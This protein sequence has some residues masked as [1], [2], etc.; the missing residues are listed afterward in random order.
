MQRVL[1]PA[2]SFPVQ[3]EPRRSAPSFA[4]SRPL[5]EFGADLVIQHRVCHAGAVSRS[6]ITSEMAGKT[7]AVL[8]VGIDEVASFRALSTGLHDRLDPRARARAAWGGLQDSAPRSALLALHARVHSITPRAWEDPSFV[9]LWLRKAAYLVP[10]ADRAVFTL[11]ALPRDPD[12][13]AALQHLADQVV[14]A[15]G[16]NAMSYRELAA[17]APELSGRLDVRLTSATGK[18][19]L[20]W[21]AS[22]IRV[23]PTSPPE[24]DEEE[25]RREL[26]RRFLSWLGPSSVR[27]FSRWSGISQADAA[28]T[29]RALEPE[30]AVIAGPSGKG[31]VLASSLD[32][33]LSSERVSGARLLAPGD[34]YL[35]AHAGLPPTAAP[36]GLADA[37]RR[38]GLPTRAVNALVGRVLLHGAVVGAWSRR[39][40]SVTIAPWRHLTDGENDLVSREAQLLTGPLGQPVTVTW[41]PLAA[42]SS[43]ASRNP[44]ASHPEEAV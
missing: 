26:A 18:V 33:L 35:Y 31:A 17:A 43:M 2:F 1:Q 32:L 8:S 7:G 14:S 19:A 44:T 29:W 41:L 13:A 16:G 42:P 23:I 21:D 15:C 3:D 12:A 6:F 39:G 37:Q 24:M 36:S 38:S 20:R 5:L 10:R 30:I 4:P 9:Q 34:P 27:Q 28:Q 11:G 40:A 22:R 25:A